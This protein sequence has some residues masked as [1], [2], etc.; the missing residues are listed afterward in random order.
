MIK[1]DGNNHPRSSGVGTNLKKTSSQLNPRG[2]EEE[3]Y[4]V[5]LRVGLFGS[6]CVSNLCYSKFN[7]SNGDDEISFLAV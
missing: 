5:L 7:G 2:K 3:I 4:A 6:H 1:R